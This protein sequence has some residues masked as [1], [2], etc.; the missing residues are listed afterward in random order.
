MRN[1]LT[2]TEGATQDYRLHAVLFLFAI[3]IRVFFLIWIDE[4]ILFFKYPFFAEKIA[5]GMDIGERLVDL[6]PFYLYFLAV[7]NKLFDVSWQFIKC[8]QIIIGAA[9]ALLVFVIGT[10]LFERR[11]AFIGALIFAAYGN[12]IV[13]E[14]TL[15]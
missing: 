8:F 6:S 4:P 12:L 15:E 11:A 13:F 3:C 9:N 7:L 14:T 10:R 2:R 1:L 5:S